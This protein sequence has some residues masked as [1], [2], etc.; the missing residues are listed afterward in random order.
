MRLLAVSLA[1]AV[2]LT[3]A[4]GG[5]VDITFRGLDSDDGVMLVAI[6]QGEKGFPTKTKHAVRRFKAP[7][8]DKASTLSVELPAGSYAISGV[9]DANGD[10]KLNLKWVVLPAEGLGASNNA[11]GNMGPPKYED[12]AFEVPAEG[13]VAQVIDMVYL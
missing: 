4:H 11:E 5:T 9:H 3:Q 7:I 6:F 13:T 1:L 8:R 2:S 10:G 12:A